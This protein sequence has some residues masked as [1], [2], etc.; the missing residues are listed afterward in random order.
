MKLSNSHSLRTESPLRTG[1]LWGCGTP[2]SACYTVH[3]STLCILNS[4]VGKWKHTVL[5]HWFGGRIGCGNDWSG[6]YSDILSGIYRFTNYNNVDITEISAK[7]YN[8]L[9]KKVSATQ[10]Q[11]SPIPQIHVKTCKFYYWGFCIQVGQDY[12][13]KKGAVKQGV[14]NSLVKADIG[15]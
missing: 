1:I 13:M 15:I 4:G 11:P 6:L 14:V 2:W 12:L 9:L 10:W 8:C 5:C 3:I 7:F